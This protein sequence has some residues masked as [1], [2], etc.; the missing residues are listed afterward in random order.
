V[1][2]GL[3]D[4]KGHIAVS[5]PSQLC[6]QKSKTYTA[7]IQLRV[8]NKSSPLHQVSITILKTKGLEYPGK[9]F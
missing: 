6:K 1:A 5:W 7:I 4:R 9:G 8:Q 3:E 2:A